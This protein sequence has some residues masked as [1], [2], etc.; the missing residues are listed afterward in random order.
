MYTAA[1]AAY[2]ARA[3]IMATGMTPGRFG[4]AGEDKCLRQGIFSGAIQKLPFVQA[5]DLAVIAGG[6]SA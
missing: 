2:T 4:V 5:E 1:L 6:N 3:R